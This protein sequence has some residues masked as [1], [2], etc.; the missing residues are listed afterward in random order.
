MYIND[1]PV[2]YILPYIEN[3]RKSLLYHIKIS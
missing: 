1:N 3:L 2:S